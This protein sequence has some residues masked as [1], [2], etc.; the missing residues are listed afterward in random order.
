MEYF[1][2]VNKDRKIELKIKRSRFIAHL[3]YVETIQQAKDFISEI[4]AEH[5][6]ANHNCWAYI[7][8]EK[9]ETF[10]SSDA[11]EPSGTAGQPML[12]ALKKHEITNVAA[13]VT[14]YFGGVKLGIRGLI[15]AYG[16]AVKEAINS[17][18]LKKLVNYK[19]YNISTTYD[20]AEI[21]KH[22]ITNMKAEI[23][24][25]EYTAEVNLQIQI[26]EHLKKELE[27]YLNEM[28][29]AGKI[30]FS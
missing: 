3:R 7:V 24:N 10:H 15:E 22:R 18:P 29:K 14:R 6:T 2:S 23:L 30:V 27:N 20:F 17:K 13:V 26:E 19:N 21:L 4:S 28:Y 25:A 12:N 9:G 1:Y 11:G 16:Q 5:K 8:G